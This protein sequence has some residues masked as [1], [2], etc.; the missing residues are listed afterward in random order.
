MSFSECEYVDSSQPLRQGDVV[1]S[2][3]PASGPWDALA[4]VV[5]ADCDIEHDKHS[6]LLTCVPVV[7]LTTYLATYYL[8]RRVAG[9]AESLSQQFFSM[10]RKVQEE[11]F[12][13]YGTPI[14][15][16]RAK[17]WVLE[18]SPTE[19]AS[20]LELVGEKRTR[21]LSIA[22]E[23]AALNRLKPGNFEEHCNAFISAQLL[24]TP[25]KDRASI[26]Q[27][28]GA[29]LRTHTNMLPG[30]ALYLSSLG[31]DL[32]RGYVVYLRVVRELR[33]GCV[34]LKS[35]RISSDMTHERVS[36]IKAPYVNALTQRL[37]A[38]FSAIGLPDEYEKART[39]SSMRLLTETEG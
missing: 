25:S 32:D 36:R 17:S 34:A 4:V 5:T 6:G 18:T 8:P 10:M 16:D 28:L 33:D 27:D 20:T 22:E 35:S 14:S 15:F 1:R 38:V 23:F 7:P 12:A 19:V 31:G 24:I 26:R 3:E 39:E 9:Q 30:D 37:G 21:F 2:L 11:K 29:V 13:N